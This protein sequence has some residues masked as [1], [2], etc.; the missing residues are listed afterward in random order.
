MRLGDVVRGGREDVEHET[1]AG[2]EQPVDGAESDARRSSS[3]SMWSSERN[4]AIT[5]GNS[6]STGGERRSPKRRSSSTPAAAA[7]SR[8][9]VI[10]PS[11]ESTP[12]TAIPA[13]A[14][15]TAMRPVPT[16]SSTTGPPERFASST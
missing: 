4:G 1:A 2:L 5:S 6:P 16:P 15:G 11:E 3:D 9:T 8:A 14:I 10:I 7:R 12:I 13:S